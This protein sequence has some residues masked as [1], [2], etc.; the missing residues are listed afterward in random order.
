MGNSLADLSATELLTGYRTASFTPS[1]VAQ[2]VLARIA[3]FEPT[4][5]AFYA[6][7]AAEVIRSAELSTARWNRQAPLGALDGVPVT[8]KE[9]VA[10]KGI[11]FPSGNAGNPAPAAAANAPITDR[12]LGAGANVLGSTTMPDWGMLSSGV[13]SLHGITRSPH[14][15]ELTTGGSSAGAGA[16]AAAGYGPLHVGTDIGG[17][18]RLP[19]TWLGLATLKPSFGRVPLDAP[20]L[21]R[22]AG[23]L[24]RTVGDLALL[25]SVIAEGDSRD[26]SQLPPERLDWTLA[27]A[28]VTGLRIAVHTDAG[29]GMDTDPETAAAIDAAAEAF[30]AGGATVE[31]IDSFMTPGMLVD[32]DR[33]WRVRSWVDYQNLSLENQ[34]KILPYVADWC[35]AGADV[36]G[37]ELLRCYQTIQSLRQATVAATSEFDLVLSPV[38]PVAAFPATWPMPFNDPQRE[39]AH[40]GFTAPYNMSEQPAASVN[41]GFTSDGR[42]IGL[43]IAGRRFDDTGVL[44]AAAWYEANRPDHFSVAWPS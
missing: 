10:R 34:R 32:L 26:F 36:P 7:D 35:R 6:H 13:S 16:A 41:C 40:I 18:I 27:G 9:N 4:I 14:D 24:A 29:C 19:G 31:R 44:R 21:G 2:D 5:N 28:E 38:S 30:R 25:M 42:T 37:A 15:P 12:V 1:D 23:P 22:C 43:Q 17:S 3:K 8:L 33:F 20:Y 11:G 39:M